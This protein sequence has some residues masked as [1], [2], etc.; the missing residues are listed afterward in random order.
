[1]KV[2]EVVSWR[3]ALRYLARGDDR[4]KRARLAVILPALAVPVVL[5]AVALAMLVLS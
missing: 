4:V 2:D 1:M 3:S 5:A